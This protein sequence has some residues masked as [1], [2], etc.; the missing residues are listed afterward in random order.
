MHLWHGV[1]IEIVVRNEETKVVSLIVAA[2]QAKHVD[3]AST[4]AAAEKETPPHRS[5]C[6]HGR[7]QQ[8]VRNRR[9]HSTTHAWNGVE[10]KSRGG[11]VAAR[12]SSTE[13]GA[14]IGSIQAAAD[15]AIIE[16]F[17]D[18]YRP[19]DGAW[20]MVNGNGRGVVGEAAVLVDD[21]ASD[22]QLR[23]RRDGEV[24]RRHR[25][26]STGA[27]ACIGA[28]AVVKGPVVVEVVAVFETGAHVRSAGINRAGEAHG[29]RR[30]RAFI[31]GRTA[32]GKG[33]RWRDVVDGE[34]ERRR[35]HE[36]RRA[37]VRCGDRN[38]RCRW[39][40]GRSV[41]PAPGACAVVWRDR[42][43]AGRERDSGV[44]FRIAES[45]SV[46]GGAAF[47]DGDRPVRR[48]DGGSRI[49]QSCRDGDRRARVVR[50]EHQS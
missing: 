2:A 49:R 42:A 20:R 48:G 19:V 47:A 32:G 9:G 14:A 21:A 15:C 27:G 8:P 34:R 43:E 13:A 31:H 37:V 5:R 22:H 50:G 6:L 29:G 28:V 38:G 44:A 17:R 3:R 25:H 33:R 45:A 35:R 36:L 4:C 11:V 23:R 30:C 10:A 1:A 41:A 40:V 16:V 18:Q 7:T 12:P 46:G 26:R 39:A 24:A